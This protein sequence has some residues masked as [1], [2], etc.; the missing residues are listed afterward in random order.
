MIYL[1]YNILLFIAAFFLIPFFAV[2]IV[3][4]GKY[5]KSIG[6][7]FGFIPRKVFE[8]MRGSPGYGCMQCR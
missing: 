3:F 8:E 1:L 4:A 5:R 6:P 7:K 2:K